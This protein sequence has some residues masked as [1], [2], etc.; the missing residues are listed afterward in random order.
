LK[1]LP[2][3]SIYNLSFNPPLAGGFF[4]S[5]KLIKQGSIT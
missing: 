5:K 3:N 4:L 2:S 1:S